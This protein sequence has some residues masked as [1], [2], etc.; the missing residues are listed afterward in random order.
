[1][2]GMPLCGAFTFIPETATDTRRNPTTATI[3]ESATP[4][5]NLI[6]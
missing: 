1:M 2:A 4:L 6:A 3:T 5:T